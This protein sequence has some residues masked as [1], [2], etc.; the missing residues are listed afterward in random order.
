MT[1]RKKVKKMFNSHLEEYT[2]YKIQHQKYGSW[3]ENC[4]SSNSFKSIEQATKA[5]AKHRKR[6]DCGMARIV[7]KSVRTWIVIEDLE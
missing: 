7:G 2:E 3:W 1:K 5:M 4:H 6:S